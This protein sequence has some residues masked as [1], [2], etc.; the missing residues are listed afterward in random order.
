MLKQR[1]SERAHDN[2]RYLQRQCDWELAW[3]A[4]EPQVEKFRQEK[5][6]APGNQ[7]RKQSTPK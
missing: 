5:W 4:I 1:D 7:S 3:V 2:A 6:D